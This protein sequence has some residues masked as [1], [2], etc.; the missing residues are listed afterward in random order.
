MD[1]LRVVK[2]NARCVASRLSHWRRARSHVTMR[3]SLVILDGSWNEKDFP[4]TEVLTSLPP[5]CPLTMEN[6]PRKTLS[7]TSRPRSLMTR[8]SAR[9]NSESLVT[10]FGGVKL[11]LHR[12][13]RDDLHVDRRINHR[14]NS[15]AGNVVARFKVC[16]R[17]RQTARRLACPKRITH[18]HRAA[19][20]ER[21]V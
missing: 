7:I 1:C 5:P 21:R 16:K 12:A 13:S 11:S 9:T 19:K 3:L 8:R 2:S 20:D 14:A 17:D 15:D 18:G 6:S 10:P 4:P